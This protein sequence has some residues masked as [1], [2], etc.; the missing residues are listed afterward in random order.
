VGQVAY[1]G[2]RNT[3]SSL[4]GKSEGKRL[5]GSRRRRWEENVDM[6]LT[7]TGVEDVGWINLAH[8]RY[9]RRLL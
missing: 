5:L 6:D 1:T 8:D 4:V 2:E 9:N 3:D 7:E